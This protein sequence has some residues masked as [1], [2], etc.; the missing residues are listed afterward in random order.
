MQKVIGVLAVTSK[1][2]FRL[3]AKQQ[4]QHRACTKSLNMSAVHQ[5]WVVAGLYEVQNLIGVLAVTSKAVSR[6]LAEQH[7][8]KALAQ[9]P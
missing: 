6:L 9:S 7:C 3:L 4:V 1:A 5:W 8:C 2:V